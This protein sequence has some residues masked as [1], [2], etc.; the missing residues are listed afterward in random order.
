MIWILLLSVSAA[1]AVTAFTLPFIIKIA[2]RVGFV[3]QPGPRKSHA[4]PMPY[5]GGIAVALG[6]L[7]ALAAG[8]AACWLIVKGH[9]FGLPSEV[10]KFAP[11]ALT[12]AP[13][14]LLLGA[15]SLVIVFLG[16]ADDRWKLTP[17]VKLLV[18]TVVAAGFVLG[19]GER[20]SLF[21]E[22]S[23][24]ANLIGG[25]ITVLWIVGVTNAFNLLDHMDGLTGGVTFLA[26]AAFALIA[27]ETGQWFVAAALTSLAGASAA[28]LLFNF[29]PARVFIGDGGS[30]F[31][32]FSLAALTVTFT[33]YEPAAQRRPFAWTIPL[34]V[35]AVPLYDMASV[36][37]TRLRNRKP[38]FE[39]DRNHVAHRLVALGMTPRGAALTVY[40]MTAMTGLA[41]TLLLQVDALGAALILAQLL[42]TFGI[43]GLL[44]RTGR[45]HDSG[46]S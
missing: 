38:I 21:L 40:A 16:T 32:G 18:Q 17:R 42:L 41:A 19:S 35:L 14:L 46:A 5:G 25:A 15:G 30:L 44:D 37:L 6:H 8:L 1:F 34:V 9:T 39:G 11:G 7:F 31:V 43:I 20:L 23:T 45:K 24:A 27:A 10:T 36:I 29:P 28:F 33:F 4:V 2:R 13:D 3:D 12:K 22:G 26:C